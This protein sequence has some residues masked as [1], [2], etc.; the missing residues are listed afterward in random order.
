MQMLATLQWPGW[1]V[2]RLSRRGKIAV[3]FWCFR[4][5]PSTAER[6]SLSSSARCRDVLQKVSTG[7]QQGCQ[8]GFDLGDVELQV[9]LMRKQQS[10]S[11]AGMN[12]GAVIAAS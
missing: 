2:D 11:F 1:R 5:A 4:G 6:R 3:V 12:D 10:H 8:H 7:F 9:G